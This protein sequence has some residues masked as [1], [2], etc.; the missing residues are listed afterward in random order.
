MGGDD[1]GTTMSLETCTA[2]IRERIGEDCGL[3]A[4]LKFNFGDDG[5]I[6]VDA[7]KI[8]N[9]ISNVES[10]AECTVDIELTDFESILS[11]D[12]DQTTAF[13]SGKLKVDN[14]GIAMKLQSIL[15]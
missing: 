6:C 11:G 14:M 8:P 10:D 2:A 4:T 3:G 9:G 12:L 13:M 15:G 7:T 1:K 5:V